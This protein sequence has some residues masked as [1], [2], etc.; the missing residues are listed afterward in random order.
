MIRYMKYLEENSTDYE[1]TNVIKDEIERI[2][3][4]C[5]EELT[6]TPSKCED[7]RR[8]L[9]KN[10]L[11]KSQTILWH[12]SVKKQ[13]PRKYADIARRYLILLTDRILVCQESSWKLE[14]NREL[15]LKAL[16]ATIDEDRRTSVAN[17]S[18][19]T[20]LFPFR[21]HAVEKSYEFLTDQAAD[22]EVW[23]RKIQETVQA[24]SK[25]PIVTWRK[26]FDVFNE[27]FHRFGFSSLY[28]SGL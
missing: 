26:N 22:R 14:F 23:V 9:D 8:R 27:D 20:V 24:L 2:A 15:S 28:R 12:G 6:I 3:R 18:T 13:S 19:N 5:G 10:E 16:K 17:S 11:L 4:R 7:L 25:R 21:V 1:H